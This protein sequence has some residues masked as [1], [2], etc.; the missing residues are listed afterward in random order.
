MTFTL[1]Y[2]YCKL[3]SFLVNVRS[4]THP[5]HRG[6]YISSMELDICWWSKSGSIMGTTIGRTKNK[7][8]YDRL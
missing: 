4:L 1:T 7:P 2:I 8:H 3:T 6:M 5:S